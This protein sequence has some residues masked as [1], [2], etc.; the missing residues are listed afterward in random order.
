MSRVEKPK[1]KAVPVVE[2]TRP[3]TTLHLGDGRRLAFGEKAEV[4]EEFAA[5]LA[6]RNSPR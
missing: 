5:I 4:S 6:A 1:A 2:N 3:G